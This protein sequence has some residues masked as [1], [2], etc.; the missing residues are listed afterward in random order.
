MKLLMVDDEEYVVESI[1][2]NVDWERQGIDEIYSASSMKQAQR[3]MEMVPID[4]IISDIV[5]PRQSG[6]D[7]IQWV[8]D[9][10]YTVQVIFLTSYA[11]FDYVR[12]AIAM[13]SVDYLLKPIDYDKLAAAVGRAAEKVKE[14]RKNADDRTEKIGRAHV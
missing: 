14:A 4:I 10:K 9:N 2:K 8:R 12:H 3:I 13:N 5:M 11:E 1:R 6:F 7:F